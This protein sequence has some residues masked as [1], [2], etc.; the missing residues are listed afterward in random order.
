MIWNIC[1]PDKA[2]RTKQD[3]R[4]EPDKAGRMKRIGRRGAEAMSLTVFVPSAF[5]E[6]REAYHNLFVEGIPH[7][8]RV[9]EEHDLIYLVDGEWEV[10]EEGTPY[11]LRAGDVLILT[12]GRHHYGERPCR[13][14]TRTIYIHARGPARSCT[15]AEEPGPAQPHGAALAR[16]KKAVLQRPGAERRNLHGCLLE[17]RGVT[18]PAL[19]RRPP[20]KR[21]EARR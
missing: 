17:I 4:S 16:V 1:L 5:Y 19:V 11:L 21:G 9:M 12:A 15:D 14:R 13:D 2:R 10:F 18:S 6:V 20:G 8:D 7:P 3:G